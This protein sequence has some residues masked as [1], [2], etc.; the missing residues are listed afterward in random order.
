MKR[1]GTTDIDALDRDKKTGLNQE[2]LSARDQW[3]SGQDM[4]EHERMRHD[5]LR[6]QHEYEDEIRDRSGNLFSTGAGR[7][8]RH[9]NRERHDDRQH[10]LRLQA[11]LTRMLFPRRVSMDKDSGQALSNSVSQTRGLWGASQSLISRGY[12]SL[13]SIFAITGLGLAAFFAAR[14]SGSLNERLQNM[15]QAFDDL[16]QRTIDMSVDIYN[17]RIIKKKINMLKNGLNPFDDHSADSGA[18]GWGIRN[19]PLLRGVFHSSGEQFDISPACIHP[20][21]QHDVALDL[22]CQR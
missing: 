18:H 6:R 19:I 16:R 14:T 2:P 17:R 15:G 10:F 11:Q 12:S 5:A 13:T 21:P 3:Q 9:T 22:H 1:K 4:P 20:M 8:V 7:L